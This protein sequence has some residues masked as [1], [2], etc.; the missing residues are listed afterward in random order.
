MKLWYI[1]KCNSASCYPVDD[2]RFKSKES[3]MQELKRLCDLCENRLGEVGDND[4][5]ECEC[6][7]N[8]ALRPL[9][10]YVLILRQDTILIK[11]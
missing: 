8:T 2:T 6:R 11:P 7:L 9:T 1:D 4:Q 10:S 3:A 5:C